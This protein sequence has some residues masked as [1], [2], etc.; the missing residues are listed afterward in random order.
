ML[1][2]CSL[3][4][5]FQ[6]WNFVVVLSCIFAFFIISTSVVDTWQASLPLLRHIICVYCISLI[7]MYLC[8]FLVHSLVFLIEDFKVLSSTN[9]CGDDY[10]GKIY[11]KL[12]K[13]TQKRENEEIQTRSC[14]KLRTMKTICY[15]RW[16]LKRWKHDKISWKR[17]HDKSCQNTK[18]CREM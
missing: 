11:R 8:L 16:K 2:Y 9:A 4:C 6:Y 14:K 15:W 12:F 7:V 10:R 5:T 1:L 13:E 18:N 17:T 3:L